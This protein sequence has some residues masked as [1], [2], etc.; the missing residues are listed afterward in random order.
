MWN[1]FLVKQTR[2]SGDDID[3]YFENDAEWPKFMQ[4]IVQLGETN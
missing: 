3:F 2:V 4:N 1:I